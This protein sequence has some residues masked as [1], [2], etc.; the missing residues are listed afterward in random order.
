M[1]ERLAAKESDFTLSSRWRPKTEQEETEMDD[2]NLNMVMICHFISQNFYVYCQ[3]SRETVG[4]S[5]KKISNWE[6]ILFFDKTYL[7]TTCGRKKH[8][9]LSTPL[10]FSQFFF[11][12]F[13][14][15]NNLGCYKS[16]VCPLL[17]KLS[18]TDGLTSVAEPKNISG[19]LDIRLFFKTLQSLLQHKKR[20]IDWGRS[21]SRSRSSGFIS[22]LY[23]TE[24]VQF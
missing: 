3:D 1:S 5:N 19:F 11:F 15:V 13:Y 9:K 18:A 17:S 12:F 20:D 7:K 2:I 21:Q 22:T 16:P 23:L 8:P 14:S 6:N 4:S 24:H 10:V